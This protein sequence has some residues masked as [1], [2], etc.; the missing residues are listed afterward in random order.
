MDVFSLVASLALKTDDYDKGLNDA[1]K[2]FGNF[3]D[4]M[5]KAGSTLSG[6]GS[7]LTNAITEPAM[8]GIEQVAELADKID[9]GSQKI[10]ISAE[11]YQ[12]WDAILQHNGSTVDILQ[13]G[14]KTLRTVM[15]DLGA[16]TGEAVVDQD[17]LHKA[18]VK[19]GNA[20]LD[21]EKAQIKYNDAVSKSGEG[22]S[23]AEKA[24]IDLE[25]AQNKVA[26]AEYAVQAAQEGTTADL[27]DAAAALL[28]LGVAATD[29]EGHLRD[30]EDVFSE[31]VT[32]LQNMENE[33]ERARIA[34]QLFGRAG[35]ELGPLLNASAEET[36]ALRRRVHELGG[37]MS[38]EAVK[39][40]AAYQDSL[41]D[42]NTAKESLVRTI[43]TSF[44]PAL[45]KVMNFVSDLISKFNGLGDG[46]QKVILVIGGL[47]AAIGPVLLTSGK[48][49]A[50]VTT[51][52][53]VLSG[54]GAGATVASTGLAATGTAA[55][56][57]GAGL[58][59]FATAAA[60]LLIG[61]AVVAGIVAGVV[62]IVK[63]WDTIKEKASEVGA[64]VA[65]KW[66]G[67]KDAVSGAVSNIAEKASGGLEK[68]KQ[69]FNNFHDNL[70]FDTG[71]FWEEI[72]FLYEEGGEGLSGIVKVALGSIN[73][74]YYAGL[75][76]ISDIT[77]VNLKGIS[78]LLQKT[79]NGI[80]NSIVNGITRAENFIRQG[81]EGITDKFTSL[82]DTAKNWGKDLIG[83]FVDGI[84]RAWEGLKN[85]V[86][87]VAQS[88]KNFLGFSEPKEGPLSNFHTFAPDMMKLFAQGIRDNEDVVYNQLKKSFDFGDALSDGLNFGTQTMDVNR[89]FS[90]SYTG[91]YGETMQAQQP[92]RIEFTGDLAQL[93]R[94]L[95]PKIIDE[96]NRRGVS[97]V[98]A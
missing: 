94:I 84:K 67:I 80:S 17:A 32:A 38:D 60:P 98:K 33:T 56:G 36:E 42:M 2:G 31:V 11:A 77:G 96:A 49:I 39:A 74:I 53:G 70:F 6:W 23:A 51:I 5:A 73:N 18:Q 75:N 63:N 54:V 21:A 68:T 85:T 78:N 35:T 71:S 14:M 4:N 26:D 27:S 20:L 58:A 48:L 82:V 81:I 44:L 93:A 47:A 46:T 72:K 55:A 12:E 64:W 95:Q 97:F 43:T 86:T 69:A 3:M 66:S 90:N 37:V 45:T 1:K 91:A 88:I 59:A 9:K 41:Q 8:R 29:S 89:R 76:L 13:S 62:L 40:G 57:A 61:G 87:S 34:S 30:E 7:T 22:S 83:N 15:D 10:G 92:I 16:A 50:P 65:D 25:K 24:L 52:T 79:I 19:Y 28:S